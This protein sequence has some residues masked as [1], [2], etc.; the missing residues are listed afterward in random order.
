[1]ALNVSLLTPNRIVFKGKAK[2]VIVP[3]EEG[4][5]EV[6]AFHKRILSRLLGGVLDIDGERFLIKRGIIKVDQN[7]VTIIVEEKI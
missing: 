3:G 2:S 7:M 1:M 4:S 5:F 6:L